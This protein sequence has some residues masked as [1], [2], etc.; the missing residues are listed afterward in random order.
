MALIEIRVPLNLDVENNIF[1]S[2]NS[3]TH[4]YLPGTL[5]SC[6]WLNEINLR[7]DN[8]NKRFSEYP[9]L[10][11]LLENIDIDMMI[12]NSY[13]NSPPEDGF[14]YLE[15]F[16][17]KTQQFMHVRG[18]E[19][20]AVSIRWYLLCN[21]TFNHIFLNVSRAKK[22]NIELVLDQKDCEFSNL[23]SDDFQ[24]IKT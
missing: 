18:G 23:K 9:Y 21:E 19:N 20:T 8:S 4:K 5:V 17:D 11:S 6:I 15:E 10:K 24:A 3:S 1:L 16:D 12:V 2:V 22:I 13:E 7:S 14:N